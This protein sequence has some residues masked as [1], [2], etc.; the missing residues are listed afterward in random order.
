MTPEVT[1]TTGLDGFVRKKRAAEILSI[2]LTT[3][4]RLEISGELV[5]TRIHGGISGY[6]EST[7]RQFIA[8]REPAVPNTARVA[9]ALA[10]PRHGRAGRVTA[11]PGDAA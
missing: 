11:G 10:S 6:R 2:S 1:A 9:A 5:P 7:L 4:W 8:T 3:L